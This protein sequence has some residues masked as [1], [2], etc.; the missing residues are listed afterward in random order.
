M[1]QRAGHPNAS[2]AFASPVGQP[3]SRRQ[4]AR[5]FGPAL[6]WIAPSTPPP[7]SND[8]FA[9]LTMVLI[10]WVVMSP[11]SASIFTAPGWP[12]GDPDANRRPN[13]APARC[14]D[15]F[16]RFIVDRAR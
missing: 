13:R 7:S 12:I 14:G 6:R 5:S 2:V 4:A 15:L 1:I 3:P 10:D 16:L 9:A 11:R 8:E